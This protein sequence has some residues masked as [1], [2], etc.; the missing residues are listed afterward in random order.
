MSLKNGYDREEI[1][2]SDEEQYA[3]KKIKQRILNAREQLNDAQHELWSARLVEPDVDYTEIEALMAWGNLVRS[4]IRDLSV[5]L[6]NDDVPES[7]RF[8]EEID[9]G[10]VRLVPQDTKHY[11][12]SKIAYDE[13]T[14]NHLRQEFG[15]GNSADIPEPEVIKFTGL[16]D[17]IE[18]ENYVERRWVVV[19]N[20]KAPKPQQELIET[21]DRKPIPKRVYER[22][23]MAADEFLQNAG[24]GLDL[25]PDGVPEW[26]FEEVENE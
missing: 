2:V 19:K 1:E 12:F 17:L 5:L 18:Q 4:Y 11:Q 14:P 3:D 10:Q 15:F 13:Y 7:K 9:L 21:G 8:R 6:K 22:A 23:L 20:P 16:Q 24:I 25:S 26:G